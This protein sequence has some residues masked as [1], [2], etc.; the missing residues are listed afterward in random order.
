MEGIR[1]ANREVPTFMM[2]FRQ[3]RKLSKMKISLGN[4][5]RLGMGVILRNMVWIRNQSNIRWFC[6]GIL[7]HLLQDDNVIL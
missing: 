6:G 4:V 7:W 3:T 5:V 2:K 1:V